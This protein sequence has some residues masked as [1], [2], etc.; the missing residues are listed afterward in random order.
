MRLECPADI[1]TAEAIAL[2]N[3][4]Q[5]VMPRYASCEYQF[6][7]QPG[8]R[9]QVLRGPGVLGTFAQTAEILRLFVERWERTPGAR[10]W[11]EVDGERAMIGPW[12]AKARTKRNSGRLPQQ[13]AQLFSQILQE[14]WTAPRGLGQE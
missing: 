7:L 11:I 5:L 10:E 13:H 4:S 12:L 9:H 2:A 3:L 6:P 8:D 14:D 1:P